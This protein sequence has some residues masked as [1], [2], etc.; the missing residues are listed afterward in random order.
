MVPRGACAGANQAYVGWFTSCTPYS[1][2]AP[3]CRA[4]FNKSGGAPTVQ[5]I[6]D[7][8]AS[9]FAGEAAADTNDSTSNS[10]QD[11]FDFLAAYF[12]GCS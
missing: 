8:L 5:D 3:C 7:F 4:D 1:A 9:Y 11:I 2:T 6:F 10:V 12:E